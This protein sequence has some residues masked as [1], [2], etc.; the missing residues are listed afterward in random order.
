VSAEEL[1]PVT[2]SFILALAGVAN[3]ASMPVV[4]AWLSW[5]V[6]GTWVAPVAAVIYWG[7]S[8]AISYGVQAA[9]NRDRAILEA[10]P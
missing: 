6:F 10:A 7:L 1:A 5:R 8:V 4:L 2:R 3:A 9:V